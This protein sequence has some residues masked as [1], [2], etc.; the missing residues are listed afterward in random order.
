MKVTY[1]IN[2]ITDLHDI[3]RKAKLQAQKKNITVCCSLEMGEG[4]SLGMKFGGDGNVYFNVLIG[5]HRVCAS[6]NSYNCI[7]TKGEFYCMYYISVKL[8]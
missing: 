5:G 4:N 7:P 8:P 3:L 2:Y 1:N 6:V